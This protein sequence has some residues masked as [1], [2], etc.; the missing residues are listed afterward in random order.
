MTGVEIALIAGVAT[1][2]AG[3]IAA[4]NA[5]K[6]AADYNAA[7]GRVNAKAARKD[8]AENARR[9]RRLNRK[10]ASVIRNRPSVSLDVLEDNVREGELMALDI[11]HKGEVKAIGLESGANLD[12]MRGKSAQ[13]AGYFSAA[14]TLLKGAGTYGDRFGG[15][16]TSLGSSGGQSFAPAQSGAGGGS[17]PLNA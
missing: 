12:K 16:T 10:N 9:Q 8:A 3:A 1:S 4:G 11:I 17:L 2:A 15:S 6:K 5:Q 7:V 14:G 13:Q